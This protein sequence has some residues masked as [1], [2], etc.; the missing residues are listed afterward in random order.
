M[1]FYET[2]EANYE[3]R[4]SMKESYNEGY[5]AGYEQGKKDAEKELHDKFM[6]AIPAPW[7]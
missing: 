3:Y 6:R 5:K 4:K 7:K 2:Q 1:G